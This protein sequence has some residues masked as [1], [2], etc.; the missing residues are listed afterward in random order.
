MSLLGYLRVHFLPRIEGPAFQL[1]RGE[2]L[3]VL[4]AGE[5]LSAALTRAGEVCSTAFGSR[6]AVHNLR[7]QGESCQSCS[8]GMSHTHRTDDLGQ[9]PGVEATLTRLVA[10][11]GLAHLGD[12]LAW[13]VEAALVPALARGLQPPL[14]RP[15]V[16]GGG[17]ALARAGHGAAALTGFQLENMF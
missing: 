7:S 4:A 12:V 16:P 17:A 8:G 2:L 11:I 3:Q 9:S 5:A 10:A 14:P 13:A 6:G 1:T 15:A